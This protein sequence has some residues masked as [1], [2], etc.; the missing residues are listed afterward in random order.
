MSEQQS[1]A[2]AEVS[3]GMRLAQA[4]TDASGRVLVPAATELSEGLLKGLER[5]GIS[6]VV[7]ECPVVVDPA[8]VEACK[9]MVAQELARLFRMAGEGPETKALHQAVLE[10]RQSRCA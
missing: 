1:L 4:V 6:H 2:V 9:A 7:V 5:R 3:A 8:A 10:F